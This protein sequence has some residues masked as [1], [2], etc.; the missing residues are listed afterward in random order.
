[1]F[2]SLYNLTPLGILQHILNL[3]SLFVFCLLH[4]VLN[5]MQMHTVAKFYWIRS[6]KHFSAIQMTYKL[7]LIL[8]SVCL[9]RTIQH[10]HTTKTPHNWAQP[11]NWSRASN[12]MLHVNC[13][14]KQLLRQCS[15][16]QMISIFFVWDWLCRT[17]HTYDSICLHTFQFFSRSLQSIRSILCWR[18]KYIMKILFC[19]T[20]IVVLNGI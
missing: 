9:I 7:F 14:R 10:W 4:I 20:Q 19:Y 8:V 18:K 13:N 15:D 5:D 6:R 2:A 11:V 16:A 3:I 12:W 17:N 1:M